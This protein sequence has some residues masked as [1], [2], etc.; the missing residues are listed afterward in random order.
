M[1]TIMLNSYC[2]A[3][4]VESYCKE[5][6]TSDVNWMRYPSFCYFDQ[7][8]VECMTS[9]LGRFAYLINNLNISGTRYLKLVY[10]TQ[11]NS[12]FCA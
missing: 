12:A 7:N 4:V 1:V 10:T 11:V 6:N 3:P 2:G 8:P 9:P 5:S